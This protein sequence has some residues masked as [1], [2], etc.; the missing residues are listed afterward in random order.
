ML[1]SA[2]LTMYIN[3]IDVYVSTSVLMFANG[4]KLYSNVCTC[5]QTDRL[6]CDLGKI[7]EWSKMLLLLQMIFNADKCMRLHV[8]RSYPSVN[9]S[10]SGVEKKNVKVEKDLGVTISYALDTILQCAKV[11]SAAN[12]VLNVN[13]RIYVYDNGHFREQLL[14]RAHCIF[15][16]ANKRCEHK[17]GKTNILKALRMMQIIFLINKLCVNNP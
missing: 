9:Y 11:V 16:K 14:Q 5:D 4:T 17:I 7:S 6:Q 10:I 13:K 3:D 15:I 1:E 12:K 8:G 2:L